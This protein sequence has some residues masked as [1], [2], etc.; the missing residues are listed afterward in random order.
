MEA[1]TI[2]RV[3]FSGTQSGKTKIGFKFLDVFSIWVRSPF[4]TDS[5]LEE[6]KNDIP[7]GVNITH[8][9]LIST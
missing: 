7:T 3:N 2:R 8:W 4:S 5:S 1:A 9:I 6:E